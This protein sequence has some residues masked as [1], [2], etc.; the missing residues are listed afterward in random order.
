MITQMIIQQS[1]VQ[2][3][4]SWMETKFEHGGIL[5]AFGSG[6]VITQPVIFPMAKGY[7][8]AGESGYEAIMP[9]TRTAGGD[10]GVKAE[11]AG[12]EV[13]VYNNNNSQVKVKE[14]QTQG[15]IRIDVMI[16]DLVSE[17]LVDGKSGQVLRNVYGL[18]P[19][20][21]SR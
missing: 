21:T 7:G 19:S 14:S 9:L 10:L 17:K 6:G 3:F 5:K 16:D 20:L 12:V 2:P 8:L 11:G 1:I 13:N 15:G 18:Q 4:M